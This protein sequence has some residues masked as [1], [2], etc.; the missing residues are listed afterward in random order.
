VADRSPIYP[1]KSPRLAGCGGLREVLGGIN[2][3]TFLCA[4]Y[5]AGLALFRSRHL[6]QGKAWPLAVAEI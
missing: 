6:A 1:G 2:D 3:P 4:E 5:A